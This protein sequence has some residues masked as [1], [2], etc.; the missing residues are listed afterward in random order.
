MPESDFDDQLAVL[1]R[2]QAYS[3][4]QLRLALLGVAAIGFLITSAVGTTDPSGERVVS[5]ATGDVKFL[6]CLALAALGV[7]AA[8]SLLHRYF[9]TDSM[10]YHLAYERLKKAKPTDERDI[11]SIEAQ[12][13]NER[14][15]RNRALRYSRIAVLTGATALCA[16][17]VL[18]VAAFIF[19][20][21]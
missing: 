10:A 21:Q 20:L 14:R 19:A 3:A 2:Y 4:E 17:A 7:S 12:Q 11:D 16:G 5:L 1:D 18:L 13:E 6:L 8:A 9:S 15:V